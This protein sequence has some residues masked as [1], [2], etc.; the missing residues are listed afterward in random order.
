MLAISNQKGG[1][2]KTTTAVNLAASLA[3]AE[4][5]V[6]LIDLDPQGNASSSV[7]YPRGAATCGTY[8]LLLGQ[9]ELE[10]VVHA[11]EL[12]SLSVVPASPD[13]AGAEIELVGFESRESVLARAFERARAR[14]HFTWEFVIL[15]CPPSLGILTL[16]ALVAA[17]SV[18]IPMQAKY[19]SLEGLGAL[20]GTIERVK[21]ALNPTLA[22][23]GIV[24]CMF[25]RRTNLAQQV[26]T[27]VESHFPG[28][29]FE[30]MIPQNVRLS[31]SPSFGKPA[32]LYDIESKGAQ[33]YLT[34][35]KE[36]LA[37][38]QAGQS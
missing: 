37:R 13:L 36:L 15:D 9:A 35:A 31:E 7:G 6:L 30:T 24:F 21:A 14:E 5:R 28:Q 32:L 11:T 12:P 16:N 19:F 27:E 25:D 1:E 23:E 29:V 33:A 18:L 20:V 17:T 10:E 8:D 4:R 38:R 34:L 3:A 2:G 22:L 26:V